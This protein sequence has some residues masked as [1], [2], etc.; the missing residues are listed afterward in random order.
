ML[1]FFQDNAGTL[2]VGIV[3]LVVVAA[4]II[5][6]VINRKRAAETGCGCGCS[7]CPNRAGCTD[8]AQTQSK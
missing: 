6:Q 1:Q 7:G 3:V 2:L 5:K 8:D 4:I